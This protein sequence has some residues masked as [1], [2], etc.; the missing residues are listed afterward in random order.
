VHA[1]VATAMANKGQMTINGQNTIGLAF[2]YKV[3]QG[4]W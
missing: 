3:G 2:A 4:Y 1:A